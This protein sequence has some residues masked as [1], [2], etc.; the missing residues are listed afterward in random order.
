MIVFKV[1]LNGEKITIAGREDLCV[2][3]AIVGASGVLGSESVGT[4]TEK[5]KSDLMLTVGGL[6]ARNEEDQGTHYDWAP[7]KILSVGDRVEITILE[8]GNAD[9]PVKEKIAKRSEIAER[10]F[11]E[12][13]KKFYFEHKEKYEKDN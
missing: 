10:A 8:Q 12:K 5:Q 2:L 9:L 1:E 11:W 4:N 3:S 6:S 13:S 7:Q